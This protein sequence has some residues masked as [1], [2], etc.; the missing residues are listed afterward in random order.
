MAGDINF[1]V[2]GQHHGPHEIVMDW[3]PTFV[4][5][6]FPDRPMSFRVRTHLLLEAPSQP[7]EKEKVFRMFEE[8][9]GNKLLSEKT[10]FFPLGKIHQKLRDFVGLLALKLGKN[11]YGF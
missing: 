7:G 10:T 9:G 3:S 11:Y 5:P 2:H 1:V 6:W 8:W 4:M